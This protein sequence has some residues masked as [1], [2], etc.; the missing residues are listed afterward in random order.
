MFEKTCIVHP[1]D[2]VFNSKSRIL[3]LGSFPSVKSREQM[4]YYGHPQNRFWKILAGI[5]EEQIPQTIEQK[6]DFLLSH[7]IALWDVIGQCEIKGSA[8]STITNPIANNLN[9]LLSET[10][11]QT[12]FCNGRKAQQEFEK[13]QAKS[14]RIQP[15]YLPS[16]SPANA[17]Y[18]LEKLI[19]VWKPLILNALQNSQA[20]ASDKE[21]AANSG[22]IDSEKKVPE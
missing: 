21:F 11:I 4:F 17:G 7:G 18:S 22:N 14:T 16:S 1:F 6:K 5:F 12:V 10:S 2:P 8:D 3:I 13:H 19:A 9:R 15:V 20:Q